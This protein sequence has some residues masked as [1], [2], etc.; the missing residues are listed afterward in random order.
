M[1][2]QI[3]TKSIMR[4]VLCWN[5]LCV[6]IVMTNDVMPN[7]IMPKI[8]LQRDREPCTDSTEWD[9]GRI[10]IIINMMMIVTYRASEGTLSWSRLHLQWLAPTPVSRR[11]DV[12]RPVVK[13]IAESLSQHDENMLYRHT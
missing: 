11:V 8:F 2:K 5:I 9:K 10:T 3:M 12:R 13:I 6:K 7:Y 1:P 4:K